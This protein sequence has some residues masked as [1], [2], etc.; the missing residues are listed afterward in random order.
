MESPKDLQA[1]SQHVRSHVPEAWIA[2][3]GWALL[4]ID[5]ILLVPAIFGVMFLPT[6][7]RLLILSFVIAVGVTFSILYAWARVH[8]ASTIAHLLELLHVSPRP[9]IAR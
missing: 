6:V 1:P 8:P 7:L 3:S 4:W 2:E 5:A 9:P